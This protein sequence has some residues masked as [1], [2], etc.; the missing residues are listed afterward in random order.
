MTN[1]FPTP[2]KLSFNVSQKE[3]LTQNIIRIRFEANTILNYLPGQ[4]VTLVI[5]NTIRRSYSIGSVPGQNFIETYVDITPGGPGSK[6]FEIVKVGDLV[7]GIF[8]IGKFVYTESEIPAVFVA[9]GT[10][11]TPFVSM[12]ETA[13]KL[14]NSKR[15]IKLVW[16]GKTQED[17]FLEAKFV[18][19]KHNFSNFD[20]TFCVS[21]EESATYS[22]GRVTNI[23]ETSEYNNESEFYICGGKEM[24]ADVETLLIT[25]GFSKDKIKYEQF[26]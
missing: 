18:E 20:F 17:L 14:N 23:L 5:S 16:G 26:Y 4:F 24:I 15:E 13:L 11:I 2:S 9:T 22:K 1:I 10:G 3:Y 8:P 21:R 7:E 25:K 19:L 12:I 6:F